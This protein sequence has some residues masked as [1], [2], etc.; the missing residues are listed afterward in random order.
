MLSAANNRLIQTP[1]SC[2]GTVAQ[3]Y[4]GYAVRW[5]P[6]NCRNSATRPVYH[7]PANPSRNALRSEVSSQARFRD[8]DSV[9]WLHCQ[10]RGCLVIAAQCWDFN[11]LQGKWVD[12]GQ[13]CCQTQLL[14]GEG[15]FR[16]KDKWCPLQTSTWR[17][18][19]LI[20]MVFFRCEKYF[21]RYFTHWRG[22]R[23]YFWIHNGHDITI[24]LAR[25]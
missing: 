15:R 5:F 25:G 16:W 6:G 10:A 7:G 24:L 21:T 14:R 23:A 19:G 20:G 2:S 17:G 9:W 1:H 13:V 4:S 3:M 12:L 11:L 18:R 22:L 8:Q